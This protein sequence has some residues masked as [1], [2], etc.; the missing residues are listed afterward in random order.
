MIPPLL[1]A[2]YCCVVPDHIGFGRNDKVTDD[3]WYVIER[4]TERLCN[5]IKKLGLTNIIVVVQD[6]GGP[7]GLINATNM[8]KRFS[9]LIILNTW[10]HHEG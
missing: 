10:L 8:P 4:D 7:V 3:K 5:F 1:A 9:R 2:G 6:W